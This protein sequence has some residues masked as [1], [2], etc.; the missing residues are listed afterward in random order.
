M[1]DDALSETESLTTKDARIAYA[2]ATFAEIL[3]ESPHTSELSMDHLIRYTQGAKRNSKDDAELIS[4]MKTAR[5][6]GAGAGS[7]VA[8]R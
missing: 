2:A 1:P 6:L 3:R 7:G 8:S 5:Q 4:L